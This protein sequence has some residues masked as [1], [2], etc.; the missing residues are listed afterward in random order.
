MQAVLD[1]PAERDY[2]VF[3]APVSGIRENNQKIRYFNFISSLKNRDCNEALK[4]IVPRVNMNEIMDLIDGTPF[5]SDLQKRFYKTML[6]ERKER[7]LDF[8]LTK[9]LKRERRREAAR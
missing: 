1:D 8:S 5:I 7:I 9:L 3:E 4:R 2:R 6:T